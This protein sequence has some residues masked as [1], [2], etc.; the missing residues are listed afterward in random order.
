MNIST[1]QV[2][3]ADGVDLRHFFFHL[4]RNRWW[5]LA[6]VILTTTASCAVAFLTRPMYR[7]TAVLM[8][9]MSGQ[10]AGIAGLASTPLAASLSGL[11][12]GGPRDPETEEALAV[13]RSREFTEKFIMDENL[14]PQL[15]PEKWNASAHRWNVPLDEQPTLAT[16]YEYFRKK[17]RSITNDRHSGLID[18]EIEWTSPTEAATWANDLIDQLNQEM[19]A[20][21]INKADASLQFL[22]NQLRYTSSV[23]VRDAVGNLIEDQLKKRMVAQVTPNYALQFAAPPVGT[24]G[25]GPVWPRKTLLLILGPVVGFFIGVIVTLLWRHEP[26]GGA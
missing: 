6:F 14:L 1:S 21:A 13:L 16:A 25:A 19:R 2:V 15:Y 7:V 5:I 17:I 18:L 22:K 20:R 4:V 9:A 10:R 3:D 11:G 23:E 26:R 8:P 12:I 24:D